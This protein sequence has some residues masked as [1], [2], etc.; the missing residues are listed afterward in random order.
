MNPDLPIAFQ[1]ASQ[2]FL[3]DQYYA[4]NFTAFLEANAVSVQSPEEI[5]PAKSLTGEKRLLL[6]LRN[7]SQRLDQEGGNALISRFLA[8]DEE[9]K[10]QK[11]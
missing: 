4:N 5:E 11:R 8:A 6:K 7:E 10:S 1:E 3:C 9:I 2:A